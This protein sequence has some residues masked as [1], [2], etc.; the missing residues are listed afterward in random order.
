MRP[1]DDCTDTKGTQC[2]S[3]GALGA[4]GCR[5]LDAAECSGPTPVP[6][7][8]GGFWASLDSVIPWVLMVLL[9][10]VTVGLLVEMSRKRAAEA[11]VR[12]APEDGEGGNASEQAGLDDRGTITDDLIDQLVVLTDF[13]QSAGAGAQLEQVLI[14][15]GVAPLN[16]NLGDRFDETIHRARVRRDTAEPAQDHTIAEV[17]RPGYRTDNRIV[18]PADVSVWI[19]G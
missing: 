6:P 9:L 19:H 11:K 10:I 5:P 2:P 15:A 7:T 3:G 18:R 12:N 17:I 1:A 8:S 13:P 14:A 16:A 4:D